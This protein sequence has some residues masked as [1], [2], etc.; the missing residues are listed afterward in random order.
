M[1]IHILILM[2]L[3][4]GLTCFELE[5][6]IDDQKYLLE[7]IA[8]TIAVM[9]IYNFLMGKEKN[10]GIVKNFLTH[11]LDLFIKNFYHLGL[12]MR[13]SESLEL[14]YDSIVN[15][16][17]IVE[18]DTANFYR[19]YF[20]GRQNVKFCLASVSTKRRQDFLTSM[21]Y[22]VFWPEKDRVLVE[23]ALPDD[24]GLKGI[25][26]IL[27]P[28]VAKKVLTEY[29]DLQIM[30]KKVGVSGINPKQLLVYAEH[31]DT[32]EYI[33]DKST[34]ED[35]N[36]FAEYIESIEL[37]DCFE[38]EIH[39]GNYIKLIMNLGKLREEDYTNISKLLSVYF[40]LIDRLSKFAPNK[41]TEEKLEENR[42][43][44]SARK[45]KGKKEEEAQNQRVEKLKNMTPAERKLYE[46]KQ[47]KRQ[48]TQMSKKFK[49][50][51]KL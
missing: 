11:N 18:E 6:L 27:K 47:E 42:K 24:S 46:Q 31:N 45:Q 51:K 1:S 43:K 26:Y 49:V 13:E 17:R 8:V 48:K 5:D 32:L 28:K 12:D 44:F 20:T 35:L 14:N 19:L 33:L 41:K 21:I 25:L 38:N 36:R 23:C 37:S 40:L 50:M 22:S 9:L 7:L 3:T 2:V 39:K 30:C 15:D 10:K 16:E 4:Q 29:E 34:I